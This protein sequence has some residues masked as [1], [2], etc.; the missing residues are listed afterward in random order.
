[1]GRIN[2]CSISYT[3]GLVKLLWYLVCISDLAHIH[4]MVV[5][6]ENYCAHSCCVFSYINCFESLLFQV[7]MM[8]LPLLVMLVIPKLINSEDPDM[9]KVMCICRKNKCFGIW[10]WYHIYIIKCPGWGWGWGAMH[11][12]EGGWGVRLL[13]IG[14]QLSNPVAMGNNDTLQ[15]VSQLP[16]HIIVG[17]LKILEKKP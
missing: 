1:M 4:K 13:Q 17:E 3:A 2:H 16:A 5:G 10:I 14:K 7:M 12:K 15:P 6:R 11:L 8:V 9:Q